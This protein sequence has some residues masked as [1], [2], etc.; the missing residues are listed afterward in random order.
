MGLNNW[1]SNGSHLKESTAAR[2]CLKNIDCF[3]NSCGQVD[4]S[5]RAQT[6][7]PVNRQIELMRFFDKLRGSSPGPSNQGPTMAPPDAR[8]GCEVVYEG[9]SPLKAEYVLPFYYG[10]S[11]NNN[12]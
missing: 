5:Q 3:P 6:G 9:E 12:W 2:K 11:P 1:E 7:P 8:V 10:S 4:S